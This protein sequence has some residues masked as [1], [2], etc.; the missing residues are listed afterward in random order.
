[1]AC[2]GPKGLASKKGLEAGGGIIHPEG[3]TPIG[4]LC[5]GTKWLE[6]LVCSGLALLERKKSESLLPEGRGQQDGAEVLPHPEGRDS[7]NE[8]VNSDSKLTASLWYSLEEKICAWD[9]E[10]CGEKIQQIM[11]M[12]CEE[13]GTGIGIEE[14]YQTLLGVD[15]VGLFPAIK[16][17][18]TGKIIRRMI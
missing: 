16:S 7:E 4:V 18:S 1:M 15:V 5:S 9:C 8:T 13:C 10:E 17:K 12:D 3:T 2:P 6:S 14:L 11:N